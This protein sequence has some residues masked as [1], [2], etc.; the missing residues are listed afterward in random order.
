MLDAARIRSLPRLAAPVLSAYL[1]T[2]PAT[3]RN[4][5]SPPGYLAWLKARARLL[6]ARVPESE[7]ALFREHVGRLERHL[8]SHPPRH[9]AVVAFSGAGTREFLPLQVKVED[10]LHWG[11]PAL[12]QLFWLLDEHQPSGAVLVSRSGA[13]FLRAWLGEV[14]EEERE[15]FAVDRSAWRRKDLVGPSRAGVRRRRGAQRDRFEARM[16]AQYGRF[17]R[18]LATRVRRWAERHAIRPVLLA[19][20]AEMVEAVFAELPEAF[21]QH[22]A[23]LRENLSYLSPAELHA[24]LEPAL[25]RRKRDHEAARVEALLSDGASRTALGVDET[26]AQ[27]QDGRVR[28]LVIA[29]GIGGTVRQCERCGR[30]DRSADPACPS[31]GGARHRVPVRAAI[32]DLARRHGVPVE[33]VAGRAA[34][35]LRGTGGVGA[36]LRGARPP[37]PS[38]SR[39]E[40]GAARLPVRRR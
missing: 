18:G 29:R 19:G 40:G 14:A 31:C 27:L 13:R 10:E 23:L 35:R 33:V 3:P 22:A 4:Q 15:T 7:R 26:L 1:D 17:A 2:N 24:R 9:R 28:E 39:S 34:T 12:K 30:V 11:P 32:P 38:V 16:K 20:P 25:E 8:H 5:G 37:R 6:D 36:W 21:R